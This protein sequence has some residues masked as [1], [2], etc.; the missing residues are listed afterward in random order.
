MVIEEIG[1]CMDPIRVVLVSTLDSAVEYSL[2]I[3]SERTKT[4]G[5]RK[6]MKT[7]TI[8]SYAFAAANWFI[9]NPARIRFIVLAILLSLMVVSALHPTL[10]TLADNVPGGTGH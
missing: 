8:K 4:P 1:C 2:V 7:N 5:A 9:S 10:I 3:K 6:T